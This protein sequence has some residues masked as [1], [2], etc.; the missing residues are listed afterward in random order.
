M[1]VTVLDVTASAVVIVSVVV[2][3]VAVF[4][5]KA[6]SLFQQEHDAYVN[7]LLLF[8]HHV[9]MPPLQKAELQKFR[10]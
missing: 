5:V 6:H 3:A 10:I 1:L 8:G 2:V 7:D 4:L 9:A